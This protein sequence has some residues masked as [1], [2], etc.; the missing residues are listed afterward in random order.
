VASLQ[1]AADTLPEMAGIDVDLVELAGD[2]AHL[3]AG[4][5]TGRS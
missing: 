1:A 2:P 3:T 4:G 5:G